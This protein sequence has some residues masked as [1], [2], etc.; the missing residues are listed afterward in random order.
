MNRRVQ[1]RRLDC[2]NHKKKSK[3][4][5]ILLIAVFALLQLALWG[6]SFLHAL[7]VK[8]VAATCQHDHVLCGCSPGRIASGTCC[9]ALALISPCCQEEYI[10]SVIEE[11]IAL[12]TAITALSCGGSEDPLLTASC[13]AYL[14]PNINFFDCSITTTRYPL[15]IAA[16]PLDRNIHPPIPPPKA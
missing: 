12:G 2:C 15:I 3:A 13:E 5:G 14:L 8:K 11:K 7:T 10:K 9:C 6:P 16:N 1:G 4:A